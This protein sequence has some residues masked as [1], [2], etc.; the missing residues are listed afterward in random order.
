MNEP[1]KTYNSNAI[2]H[3]ISGSM[4]NF[5]TVLPIVLGAALVSEVD[6]GPALLFFGVWYIVMGIHYGI[7]MS[8][9]PMKAIGAIAIAEELTSGEIAASGMI[10][11]AALL[12]LGLFRGFRRLQG[13]IPESVVRG[14]QLGLGLIL[15]RTSLGFISQDLFFSSVSIGIVLL[16]LVAKS[17]WNLPDLSILVVF[18][19]GIGYGIFTKGAPEIQMISI[20]LLPVPGFVDFLWSGWH[21]VLPQIPLALTNATVAAALTAQDL[22]KKRIK[23][24]QLCVSMG[25]MNLISVPFGGFP[26]CHGAGGLAAHRRFGAKT[27]LAT[28]IGGVILLV[29]AFFFAGPEALALLPIGLFGALLLFVALELGR[30]GLRTDAPLLTGSMALLALFTNVGVAFIFGIV[31]AEVMK[32]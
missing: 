20:D 21:L 3:E 18:A 30:C 24:D 17:R 2:L 31:L 19:I 12:A 4:G 9:E 25:V 14:V 29:V 22:F 23:P 7:P 6:L 1:E 26:M 16:F 27:G 5:A 13:L 11:G 32:R 10:L 28:V 15:L 8:V